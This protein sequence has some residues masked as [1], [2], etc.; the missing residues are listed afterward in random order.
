[1]VLLIPQPIL[2]VGM[3][4]RAYHDLLWN[5][6]CEMTGIEVQTSNYFIH[7]AEI[8]RRSARKSA[9]KRKATQMHLSF[10]LRSHEKKTCIFLSEALVRRTFKKT[11]R[12]QYYADKLVPFNGSWVGGICKIFSQ[13]GAEA[14]QSPEWRQSPSFNQMYGT[15]QQNFADG[16]VKAQTTKA[17]EEWKASEQAVSQ[18]AYLPLGP[19]SRRNV[20]EPKIQ[21]HLSRDA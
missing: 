7:Q 6:A 8:V 17:T 5:A 13:N 10:G 16:Q 4:F 9:V 1:M 3:H 21:A 11:L 19:K 15:Y 14:R 12:N 20:M 18:K 2:L